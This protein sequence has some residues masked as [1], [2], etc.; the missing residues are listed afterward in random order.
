MKKIL[1]IL[2]VLSLIMSI[3]II[4]SAF[5]AF[6]DDTVSEEDAATTELIPSSMLSVNETEENGVKVYDWTKWGKTS[7]TFDYVIE[8]GYNYILEFDYKSGNSNIA[9]YT[10]RISAKTVANSTDN[11]TS[12][13]TQFVSLGMQASTDWY[14]DYQVLLNGDDLLES[15]GSYL[16]IFSENLEYSTNPA[17]RNFSITK[18]EEIENEKNGKYKQ[19]INNARGM[20]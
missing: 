8:S 16:A 20:K 14:T 18:V 2:C 9:G 1:S 7:I 6:A 15:G 13:G 10:T 5:T 11:V 19:I 12:S 3:A 17:F 4:P